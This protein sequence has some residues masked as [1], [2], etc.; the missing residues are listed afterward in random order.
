LALAVIRCRPSGANVT[1]FTLP[2]RRKVRSRFALAT[3]HK[4]RP[5]GAQQASV[6]PSG[7]NASGDRSASRARSLGLALLTS[8]SS[9]DPVVA[10]SFTGTAS[11][12]PS[13]AQVSG[14]GQSPTT[15]PRAGL[16]SPRSFGPTPLRSHSST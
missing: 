4:A 3:S 2:G 9:P 10:F 5:E 11:V 7:A 12:L 16:S 6:L 1:A 15:A 14:A 13:G 8:H